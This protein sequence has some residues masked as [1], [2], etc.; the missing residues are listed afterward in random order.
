MPDA[1]K[2]QHE[3]TVP[4]VWHHM[5]SSPDNILGHVVLEHSEG[6]TRAHGYFND[7]K[8]GQNAK[9]LVAHKDITFLS[10]Y[11]NQL[12]ERAKQVFHGM[13]REVSLVTAGANP[14]AKIDFIAIQHGDDPND[15]TTSEDEAVIYTGELIEFIVHEDAP[16]QH[17]NGD[18]DGGNGETVGDV[19]NTLNE[20]QKNAVYYMLQQASGGSGEAEQSDQDDNSLSHEGQEGSTEMTRNVFE[21]NGDSGGGGGTLAVKERIHLSADQVHTIMADAQRVGS[22]KEAV[23]MHA[24]EYGIED[25]EL[26]FPDARNI[27]GGPPL[28]MHRQMDWVPGVMSGT[29]HSPFS[30]VKMFFADLTQEEARAKG[31]IKTQMK[32][33]EWFGVARRTTE[34]CT[35]YKKQKLDRDDIVDIVDFDVVAW[36]RQEM[37]VM[38]DE[39]IARAVLLGDGREIDDPDKILPNC[40]RPIVEEPDF[41]N[42]QIGMAD[43]LDYSGNDPEEATAAAEEFID[44]IILSRKFYRGS[45]APTFFTTEDVV[46]KLL[47]QRDRQGRRLYPTE[48]E[49]ASGLR[50][51]KI[52]PVEVME[53]EQH[54]NII[55]ILVNLKDYTIGADKGGQIANFDDFDIDFNQYKYLMETRL[56]GALTMPKCCITYTRGPKTNLGALSRYPSLKDVDGEGT[57]PDAIWG[58]RK[59]GPH[60]SK[61]VEDEGE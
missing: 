22:F 57:G 47:L 53:A 48:A 20:K 58:G 12:V 61:E 9:K 1:F 42:T 31:Y 14:G 17:Q 6:S 5:H 36:V 27:R 60:N 35:I 11:A 43:L 34:P 4:L 41:Y 10:I 23:L 50:V 21:Q 33:E 15:L 40:L 59:P 29:T 55:G 56:S 25:I 37:R 19:F 18:G 54:S 32:K 44:R 52:V 51:S 45:G 49:L 3:E 30:R 38:L 16:V 8:A 46:S 2:H 7:T 26:L 13:I 39:E 24:T 28:A